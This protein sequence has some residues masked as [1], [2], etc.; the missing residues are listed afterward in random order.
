MSK[1]SNE[2]HYKIIINSTAISLS[3]SFTFTNCFYVGTNII[4]VG[5]ISS[6]ANFDNTTGAYDVRLGVYITYTF[7]DTT[8]LS[9]VMRAN[10]TGNVFT[11]EFS[12]LMDYSVFSSVGNFLVATTVPM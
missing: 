11:G 12:A 5:I 6:S 9:M 3:F 1:T 7:S 10:E 2:R 8:I 4:L